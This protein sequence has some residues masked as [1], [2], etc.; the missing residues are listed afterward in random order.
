MRARFRRV[1][2]SEDAGRGSFVLKDSDIPLAG[3]RAIHWFT[4][5]SAD[6]LRDPPERTLSQLPMA[7]PPGATTFQ[8]VV[9][10][11]ESQR[12]RQRVEAFYASAFANGGARSDT[13]RHPGMHRTATIDYIV[14]LEGELVLILSV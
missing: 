7:P 5:R 10:P 9:V 12:T 3:V 6:P 14:V 8:I 1:V 13:A 4:E 11:P 2:T